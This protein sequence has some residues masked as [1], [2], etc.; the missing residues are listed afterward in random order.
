LDRSYILNGKKVYLIVAK[1]DETSDEKQ[2]YTL[3]AVECLIYYMCTG[4]QTTMP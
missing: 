1:Y 2:C 3:T 4:N